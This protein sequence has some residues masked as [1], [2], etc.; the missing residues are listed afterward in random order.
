MPSQSEGERVGGVLRGMV[1]AVLL[2]LVVLLSPAVLFAVVVLLSPAVL[3]A[4]VVLLSPAVLFAVVV[5]CT[6]VVF[7]SAVL[8]AVLVLFLPRPH[9]SPVG[10]SL[11]ESAPQHLTEAVVQDGAAHV[12]SASH[13]RGVMSEGNSGHVVSMSGS[14]T[15]STA[16]EGLRGGAGPRRRG[17]SLPSTDATTV[18]QQHAAH[19]RPTGHRLGLE[20]RSIRRR[21]QRRRTA[22]SDRV[23]S[24]DDLRVGR[25]VPNL[26]EAP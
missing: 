7:S 15:P 1:A 17:R 10:I 2:L 23:V 24:G 11:G 8:F 9:P 21:P 12:V 22:R 5:L 3:F 19:V 4:V 18:V 20:A 6:Q 13:L 25:V 26:A 16:G 14:E